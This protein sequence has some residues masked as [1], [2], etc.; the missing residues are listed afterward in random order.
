MFVTHFAR[1]PDKKQSAAA[2]PIALMPPHAVLTALGDDEAGV[3]LDCER[4]VTRL[5]DYFVTWSSG[6][7]LGGVRVW[8]RLLKYHGHHSLQLPDGYVKD[9]DLA[10]FLKDVDNQA[11]VKV[12]KMAG[13]RRRNLLKSINKDA[14]STSRANKRVNSGKSAAISAGGH[15]K[16]LQRC[17][18]FSSIITCSPAAA[19]TA[20]RR[21]KN[22][23]DS[24]PSLIPEIML[25]IELAA[26]DE[27]L[28]IFVRAA[29]SLICRVAFGALRETQAPTSVILSREFGSETLESTGCTLEITEQDKH[30]DPTLARP[31][32]WL[33]VNEGLVTDTR[34]QEAEAEALAGVIDSGG[35]FLGRNTDSPS[36][37]PN[38]ADTTMFV[39]SPIPGRRFNHMFR[40]VL[41][42][43][44]GLTVQEAQA[45]TLSSIRSF[46][47]ECAALVR[48]R[49]RCPM[50]SPWRGGRWR[51]GR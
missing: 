46:L 15:L 28:P 11:R 14:T 5:V 32:G 30:P 2:R 47:P 10:A 19:S 18:G 35:Y 34:W 27:S 3:A 51:G 23:S 39:N 41:H 22:T 25:R 48:R 12:E 8:A 21:R 24:S 44:V 17:A 38:H 40:G 50:T 31:C 49:P 7:I 9:A 16:W 36:G 33:C 1:G 29:C 13:A 4:A 37:D 45:F 42:H 43:Q 6:S 26:V 20:P